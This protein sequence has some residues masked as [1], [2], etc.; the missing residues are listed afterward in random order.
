LVGL[1]L[2]VFASICE[3]VMHYATR[4]RGISLQ[5]WLFKYHSYSRPLLQIIIITNVTLY[6]NKYRRRT[7]VKISVSEAFSLLREALWQYFR[8]NISWQSNLLT[9][10]QRQPHTIQ[11]VRAHT[12]D[13]TMGAARSR[14]SAYYTGFAPGVNDHIS[15][16]CWGQFARLTMTIT[17]VLVD[18]GYRRADSV[19][20]HQ[21]ESMALRDIIVVSPVNINNSMAEACTPTV[22]A[23]PQTLFV[24]DCFAELS[25]Y[26][27]HRR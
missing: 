6:N 25:M 26:D 2:E 10:Q 22:V 7:S 16:T 9:C 14:P 21:R 15:L 18:T 20:T 3:R 24:G 1:E 13:F 19:D 23:P 11:I 12:G 17:R 27:Q 4:P 8:N 5:R